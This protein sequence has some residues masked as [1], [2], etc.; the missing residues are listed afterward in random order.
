MVLL[1]QAFQL[2]EIAENVKDQ[3]NM[4]PQVSYDAFT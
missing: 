2:A 3:R 1:Y 4:K